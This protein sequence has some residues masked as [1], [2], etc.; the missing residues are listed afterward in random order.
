VVPNRRGY[1][2][3]MRLMVQ[4]VDYYT[5]PLAMPSVVV[6]QANMRAMPFMVMLHT[7]DHDMAVPLVMPSVVVPQVNITVKQITVT[8]HVADHHMMVVLLVMLNMVHMDL[9][10]EMNN[11]F[12][13]VHP[14][15][16]VQT[17]P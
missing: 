15:V 9:E 2:M 7:V 16:M 4:M 1:M 8:R 6:P 12:M 5:L 13:M 3:V 14:R 10:V 17:R 11:P